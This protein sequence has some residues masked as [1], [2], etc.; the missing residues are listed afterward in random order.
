[1]IREFRVYDLGNGEW[2]VVDVS[3]GRAATRLQKDE[4]FYAISAAI[5][6]SGQLPPFSS[7]IQ[8]E[9]QKLEQHG[10]YKSEIHAQRSILQEVLKEMYQPRVFTGDADAEANR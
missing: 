2:M 10:L 7:S 3:D 1:M 5:I 8:S 6:Q 4:A 9:I